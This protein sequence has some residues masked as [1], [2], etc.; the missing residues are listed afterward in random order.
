MKIYLEVNIPIDPEENNVDILIARLSELGF[1]GF[2]EEAD[3][4]LAYCEQ[5]ETSKK[6]L[7]A[8]LRDEGIP[9]IGINEIEDEN[10]N[11]SW[12]SGYESVI[13][14][15]RIMVRA[16]FHPIPEK[17][18]YDIIIEPKM[19]FGT[20]HH[21]TTSLMLE[22]LLSLDVENKSVLDMGS[23]TGV[24]AILAFMK[25]A[26]EVLAIDND[27]WAWQNALD[28]VK[29]NDAESIG[30]EL[31]DAG[32]INSRTFRIIFANINR[33]I[34][35]RDIPAYAEA[36]EAEGNL[37]LSGFYEQ[38]LKQIQEKCGACGLT[39]VSAAKKNKWTA[40]IFTKD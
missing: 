28:N 20:A 3:Y 13:I 5:K 33:N 38:D 32:S 6:D 7:I 11:A 19:S 30:V 35:L 15:D 36:L 8:M 14:A 26:K 37:L 17:I 9:V 2:V 29:L 18:K 1:D 31:G 10:W 40:A 27:T 23:G 24:L 39:F 34:L 21:E 4:I 12:E 22:F 25:G 16:P